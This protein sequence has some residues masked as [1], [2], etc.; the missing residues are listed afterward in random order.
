MLRVVNQEEEEVWIEA[1][2]LTSLCCIAGSSYGAGSRLLTRLHD[3]NVMQGRRRQEDRK[4]CCDP[5]SSTV[6]WDLN[7]GKLMFLFGL[8]F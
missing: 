6:F 4:C 7:F 2:W 5:Y 8:A 1:V 3:S